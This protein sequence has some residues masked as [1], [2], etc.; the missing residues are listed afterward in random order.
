[1]YISW[2]PIPTFR[3]LQF[4]NMLLDATSFCP[5]FEAFIPQCQE[6]ISCKGCPVSKPIKIFYDRFQCTDSSP[7]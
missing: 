7:K 5:T 2:L 1:M 3:K 4:Q 6:I